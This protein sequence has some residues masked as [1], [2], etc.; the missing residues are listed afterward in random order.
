MVSNSS[1]VALSFFQ[2]NVW[3]HEVTLFRESGL[4]N[5]SNFYRPQR[6]CGKVMFLHVSVILFTG[7][8]GVWQADTLLSGR[9]SPAGRQPPPPGRATAADGTHPTGML[10]VI[11]IFFYNSGSFYCAIIGTACYIVGIFM[12]LIGDEDS[13]PPADVKARLALLRR[14]KQ[15]KLKSSQTIFTPL[16]HERQ[17]WQ[18]EVASLIEQNKVTLSTAQI[19]RKVF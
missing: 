3:S 9:Q 17:P 19:W 5:N 10:L 8:R 7:G 15:Q 4:E 18:D 6:S 13:R 12:L 2:Q 1:T 16:Q 11:L 14:Q